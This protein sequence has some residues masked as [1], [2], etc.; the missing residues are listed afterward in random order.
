[1]AKRSRQFC[2]CMFL[3][4]RVNT[5]IIFDPVIDFT[6]LRSLSNVKPCVSSFFTFYLSISSIL[7]SILKQLYYEHFKNRRPMSHAHIFAQVSTCI[8]ARNVAQAIQ[9]HI[10]QYGSIG[11]RC[12]S[13]QYHIL[14]QEQC[15]QLRIGSQRRPLFLGMFKSPMC[16]SPQ[17]L[18]YVL[19]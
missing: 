16:H 8:C 10:L 1:M 12:A 5:C 13:V 3:N 14:L 15:F 19:F 17:V 18:L 4:E 11:L 2:G 6:F 7:H 9:R